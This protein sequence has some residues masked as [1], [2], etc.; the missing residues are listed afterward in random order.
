MLGNNAVY[1]AKQIASL[2]LLD[3]D[4]NKQISIIKNNE[5]IVK[6]F[7]LAIEDLY[8]MLFHFMGNHKLLNLYGY[9]MKFQSIQS[10]ADNL[11]LV[12]KDGMIWCDVIR[13]DFTRIAEDLQ[14]MVNILDHEMT[15]NMQ[16]I[17]SRDKN[18]NRIPEETLV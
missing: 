18:Y 14:D 3:M 12:L 5:V 9:K 13:T 6:S 11:C 15:Y 16:I 4:E 17:D 10:I 2:N 8:S 7:K 1:L